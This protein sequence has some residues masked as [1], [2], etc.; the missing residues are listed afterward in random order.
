MGEDLGTRRVQDCAMKEMFA[1]LAAH[2]LDTS[3]SEYALDSASFKGMAMTHLCFC[4][5]S[6]SHVRTGMSKEDRASWQRAGDA[7]NRCATIQK[8]NGTNSVAD[9]TQELGAQ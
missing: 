5:I 2:S 1:I 4:Y 7:F 6:I 3:E 8:L 9:A